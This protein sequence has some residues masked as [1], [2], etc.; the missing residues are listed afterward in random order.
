MKKWTA[1]ILALAFV[2]ALAGC[3]SPSTG[4]KW[5]K[6]PMVMVDGILYL[7]TGCTAEG[8]HGTADGEITSTVDGS[9]TPAANSQSNFGAGYDY[10]YGETAG[11]VELYMN[12]TWRIFAVEAVRQEIQFPVK[13]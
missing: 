13:Q 8:G 2:S 3:Q 6:I 9:E 12:E 1:L 11:T 10:R 5:D 4:Q 7:D